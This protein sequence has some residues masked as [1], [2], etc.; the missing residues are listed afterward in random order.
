MESYR[1]DFINSAISLKRE[2]SNSI[3][4]KLDAALSRRKG[5]IHVEGIKK[6]YMDTMEKKVL[7]LLKDCRKNK[8]DMSDFMLDE[9]FEKMWQQ[10]IRTL[11]YTSLKPQD[12]FKRVI[13]LLRKNLEPRGSSMAQCLK[14]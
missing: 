2:I 5:M 13:L 12:I 4:I 11:S 3:R 8:S 1:Q 6:T 7:D 14:K 10:T 9:A